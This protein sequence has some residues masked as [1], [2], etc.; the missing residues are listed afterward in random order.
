M[1]KHYVPWG[2]L[3]R[4]IPHLAARTLNSFNAPPP[5]RGQSIH[6]SRAGLN[7][8]D[9]T[10]SPLARLWSHAV[11]ALQRVRA[12]LLPLDTLLAKELRELSANLRALEAF[13][14]RVALT[15]ALNILDRASSDAHSAT[16]RAN[17][18]LK[19][20]G[21]RKRLPALRLWPRAPRMPVRVT[22]LGPPTS[23]REIW[24]EQRRNALIARLKLARARTKLTHLK[25]A[26][27]IDALQR[28]LDAPLAAVRRLARKLR[29]APKLAFKIAM[30]PGPPSPHLSPDH[31]D[32][33]GNLMWPAL[34]SS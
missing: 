34:N 3:A 8:R 11:N 25:L 30:R 16:P 26:D 6:P 14:R 19:A 17:A 21:P 1:P 27:R 20:R 4:S 9:M 24:R 33:L 31:I 29:Q 5:F 12:T 23:M 10:S 22:L 18:G 28:F 13:C 2:F 32:E 7:W 15:E